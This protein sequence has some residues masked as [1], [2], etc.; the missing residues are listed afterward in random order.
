MP[1]YGKEVASYALEFNGDDDIVGISNSADNIRHK[2][3]ADFLVSSSSNE[4]AAERRKSKQFSR[5]YFPLQPIFRMGHEVHYKLLQFTTPESGLTQ[6]LKEYREFRC[7]D[8]N[9]SLALFLV[10]CGLVYVVHKC[11]YAN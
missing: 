10:L 11:A 2:P 7:S 5:F 9:I 3:T 1:K 8:I 6:I 4:S